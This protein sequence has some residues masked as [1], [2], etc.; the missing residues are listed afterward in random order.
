MELEP[1]K[2]ETYTKMIITET[3]I[4]K[5]VHILPGPAKKEIN[6]LDTDPN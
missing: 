5:P 2:K 6:S 3:C 1:E 4:P